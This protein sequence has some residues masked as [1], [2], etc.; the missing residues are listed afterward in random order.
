MKFPL[1]QLNKILALKSKKSTLKL[2]FIQ[3]FNY[4]RIQAA[5]F[6]GAQI[7]FKKK[8]VLILYYLFSPISKHTLRLKSNY[9]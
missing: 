3:E 5:I 1:I 4:F 9:Q 2:I 8:V 7:N 6:K